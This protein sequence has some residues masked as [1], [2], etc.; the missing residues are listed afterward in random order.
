MLPI[1]VKTLLGLGGA[2]LL[3]VGVVAL[4]QRG[5]IYHPGTARIR[6]DEAGVP[7]MVPV[8]VRAADGRIA[9]GWYAP[10]PRPDRP[11]VL[12]FHGNSGTLA[13]RAFKARTFIDAGFGVFLAGYRGFGGDAGSPSEAGLYADAEAA[14][15]WLAGQGVAPR[16][17][18]LYGESLGTGVAVEMALRHPVGAVVLES[19]FT[20]LA[21]L[22][23]PYVLPPLARLLTRD[24][25]ENLVKAPSLR[26]PLL[27]LHGDRDTLVPAIMGHAVLNAAGEPKEG[28][29]IPEAGH[30]D[31]WDHGAG[32]RTVEFISR[33]GA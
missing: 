14:L 9:T 5:M 29:F 24:R 17:L 19:P 22:A 26:A 21:D 23:P 8:P 28:L 33:R 16:R 30:N 6:P 32:R 2:Y 13:D 4:A 3:L 18:T 12:L 7:E 1:M 15:G 27:V 25:F 20:A 10:A 31:L 11:V